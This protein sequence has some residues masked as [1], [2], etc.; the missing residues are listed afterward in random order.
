[1]TESR[2]APYDASRSELTMVP[3]RPGAIAKLDNERV[4]A[5][6]RMYFK[7]LDDAEIEVALAVTE[8]TGLSPE[9]KQIYFI[10]RWDAQARREVMQP[11]ISIDGFRLIAERSG[12]YVGQVGPWWCGPDG[13]WVD[14]WLSDEP[15]AAAKVGVLNRDFREPVYGVARY[16]SYVQ[17]FLPKN[18]TTRVP[19][20]LWQSMPDVMS[21]KCAEGLALRKAF[22]QELAG[23]MVGMEGVEDVPRFDE[24][25]E[26]MRR[27]NGVARSFGIDHDDIKPFVA[28]VTKRSVASLG[29]A[30]D[31]SVDQMNW[32]TGL[33]E[34]K[35]MAWVANR[36]AATTPAATLTEM[37]TVAPGGPDP[38]A[39]PD[40]TG[41]DQGIRRNLRPG[42]SLDLETGEIVPPAEEPFPVAPRSLL[43]DADEQAPR[44]NP[45][46]WTN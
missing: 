21:A 30:A 6:K 15:P 23:L 13:I 18:G 25:I 42:E 39:D 17:T 32:V 28:D 12:K 41:L 40:L 14:V 8:R 7:G 22:P 35:G 4:E 5:L 34:D 37:T 16:Q 19:T 24:R 44:R 43:T 33:I 38:D 46:D 27:M 9:A 31:W 1:M 3:G 26:A 36:L 11:Q 10:K 20:P 29:S 2:M 45:D